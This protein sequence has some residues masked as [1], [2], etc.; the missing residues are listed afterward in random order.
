M[1]GYGIEDVPHV[2]L[3]TDAAALLGNENTEQAALMAEAV[4]QVSEH[5]QVLGPVSK[6]EAHQGA[7]SFHRAF[8][9][10]LFNTKGEML[11]QQR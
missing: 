10:L 1:A 6:L 9:V 11:L 8:S 2:E 5:D 3:S 7:G 4:I